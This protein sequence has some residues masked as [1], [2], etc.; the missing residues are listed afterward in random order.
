[1]ATSQHERFKTDIPLFR[2]AMP[3]ILN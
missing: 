1:M 2:L 3:N